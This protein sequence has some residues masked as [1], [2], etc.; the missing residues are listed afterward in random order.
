MTV[1]ISFINASKLSE[2]I[3]GSGKSVVV[4]EHFVELSDQMES[5]S[6]PPCN[7]VGRDALGEGETGAHP[8]GAQQRLAKAVGGVDG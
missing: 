1:S 5:C 6:D 7:V 8:P 4:S 2:C 3:V